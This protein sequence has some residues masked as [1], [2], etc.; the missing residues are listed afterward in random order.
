MLR[1]YKITLISVSLL[2]MN[3]CS[4]LPSQSINTIRVI[5][6]SESGELIVIIK[7]DPQQNSAIKKL[8]KDALRWRDQGQ[9][10][11]AV[12]TLERAL[13]IKPRNP[14]IWSELAQLRYSQ[15]QY[16][17]A[18]SMALRSNHYTGANVELKRSNWRLIAN[19]RAKQ[20]NKA[21]SIAARKKSQE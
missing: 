20:G 9:S 3:A 14:F 17:Q 19:A 12:A 8:M 6:K 4:T 7:R 18:E 10:V 5:D 1:K 2:F 15:Q 11:K 21:G 13:R 16:R